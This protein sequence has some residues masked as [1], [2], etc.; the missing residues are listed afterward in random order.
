MLNNIIN[1]CQKFNTAI[2]HK[3]NP[4][5]EEL[6]ILQYFILELAMSLIRDLDENNAKKV[7]KIILGAV[8]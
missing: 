7:A 2:E 1:I 3:G 5:D 4:T 8:E 6:D